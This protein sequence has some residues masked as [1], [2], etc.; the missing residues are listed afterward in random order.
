MT[1]IFTYKLNDYNLTLKFYYR[2]SETEC[3]PLNIAIEHIDAMKASLGKWYH[4]SFFNGL[5]IEFY[6]PLT[7]E[8]NEAMKYYD[9]TTKTWRQA[10]GLATYFSDNNKLIKITCNTY[11]TELYKWYGDILAHEIGHIFEKYT[12]W[13]LPSPLRNEWDRIRQSVIVANEPVVEGFAEDYRTFFGPLVARYNRRTYQGA[14]K[15]K[16]LHDML[17]LY[18]K[19][20]DIYQSNNTEIYRFDTNDNDLKYIGIYFATFSYYDFFKMFPTYFYLNRDNLFQ[21]VN[22]MWQPIY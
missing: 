16:G 14:D 18:R 3:C 7:P 9:N 17:L 19:F 8:H 20:M 4:N 1:Q 6:S 22:N 21:Y 10:A 13:N 12:R 2:D 15:V 11:G 5:T